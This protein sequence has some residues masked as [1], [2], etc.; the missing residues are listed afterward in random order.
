[1]TGAY[2]PFT[3]HSGEDIEEF[4]EAVEKV[5]DETPKDNIKF[6]AGNWNAKRN[7]H[8]PME[9]TTTS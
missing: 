9:W 7:G 4:Y 3:D 2:Q 5:M 8:Q 6:L 1:M